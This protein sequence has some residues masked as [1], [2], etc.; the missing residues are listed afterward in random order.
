MFFYV[1]ETSKCERKCGSW[2][3]TFG[4]LALEKFWKYYQSSLYEPDK[5]TSIANGYTHLS[6]VYPM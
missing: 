5:S 6:Y 1:H 3:W 2:F 4:N